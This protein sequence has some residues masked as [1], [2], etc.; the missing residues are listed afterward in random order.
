MLNLIYNMTESAIRTGL[1]SVGHVHVSGVRLD[2]N[3]LG[4]GEKQ[5]H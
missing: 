2:N 1:V 5:K 4:C 3:L